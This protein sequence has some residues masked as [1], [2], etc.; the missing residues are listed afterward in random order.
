MSN[1]TTV[2][3]LRADVYKK[4]AEK[5]RQLQ[6]NEQTTALQAGYALGVEKVLFELRKELVVEDAAGN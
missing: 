1:I 5:F 2:I 6:P 3:R 4:F